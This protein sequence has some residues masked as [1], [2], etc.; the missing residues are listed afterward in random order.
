MDI[1]D[2]FA[3]L[4]LDYGLSSVCALGC[5]LFHESFVSI[6]LGCLHVERERCLIFCMLGFRVFSG[7][8]THYCIFFLAFMRRG[9]SFK[10]HISS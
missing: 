6:F 3:S 8:K 10:V 5:V 2:F 4:C 7:V 1:V 9:F